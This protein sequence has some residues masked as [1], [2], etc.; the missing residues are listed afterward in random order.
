MSA[1]R[2]LSDSTIDLFIVFNAVVK[3]IRDFEEQYC[4]AYFS[5]ATMPA[6][7]YAGPHPNQLL[8]EVLRWRDDFVHA[9]YNGAPLGDHSRNIIQQLVSD[10]DVDRFIFDIWAVIPKYSSVE[11][12]LTQRQ[13][14][15]LMTRLVGALKRKLA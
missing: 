4:Q 10:A 1:R 3:L 2:F 14:A 8:A 5:S 15:D 13:R 7:P 9:K 12:E 11:D 6:G